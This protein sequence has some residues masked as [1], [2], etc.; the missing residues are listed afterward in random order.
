MKKHLEAKICK[1]M[2]Q[3]CITPLCKEVER[4][5]KI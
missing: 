5:K 2:L 4:F 1:C 3:R